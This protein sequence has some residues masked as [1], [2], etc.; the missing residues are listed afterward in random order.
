MPKAGHHGSS[1]GP[2]CY[3]AGEL[4]HVEQRPMEVLPDR[5]FTIP[6]C[7]SVARSLCRAMRTSHVCS[8]ARSAARFWGCASAN[9]SL[10]YVSFAMH[11]VGKMLTLKTR[12]AHCCSQS[13]GHSYACLHHCVGCERHDADLLR[14]GGEAVTAAIMNIELGR[15]AAVCLTHWRGL[16]AV[17]NLIVAIEVAS[18]K[19][20]PL[21]SLAHVGTKCLEARP[22]LVKQRDA[23]SAIAFEAR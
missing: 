2:Q 14:L 17:S 18:L 13:F 22:P 23:S 15:A 21:G 9:T 8:I 20:H 16:T 5:R 1:G 12:A 7:F 19:P 4:H 11:P 3:L 6:T 10:K